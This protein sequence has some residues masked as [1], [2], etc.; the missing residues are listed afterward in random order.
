MANKI[1]RISKKYVHSSRARPSNLYQP[2]SFPL[3]FRPNTHICFPRDSIQHRDIPPRWLLSVHVDLRKVV[4]IATWA[5]IVIL[6]FH[7]VQRGSMNILTQPLTHVVSFAVL[8]LVWLALSTML[9]TQL[10][11]DCNTGNHPDGAAY[12]W[13]AMGGV[14]TGFACLVFLFST[15]S[16]TLV[17]VESCTDRAAQRDLP[18]AMAT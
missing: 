9:A 12:V 10:P 13:C 5:W 7:S 8:T 16:L 11:S 14:S 18:L 6:L 15:V 3:F 17:Y 1:L 4:S 2:P